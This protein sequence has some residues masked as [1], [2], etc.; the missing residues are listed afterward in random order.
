[1]KMVIAGGRNFIGCQKD[2]NN[3][4]VIVQKYN[5]TEIISG[6]AKGADFFGEY[7]A[8]KMN[9]PVKKFIPDWSY[10]HMAGPIRN[11]QMAK[12]TDYVFLFPGGRGTDSMRREA[13][14]AGKEILYDNGCIE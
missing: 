7:C 3:V 9:I 4:V 11:E 6:D 12:Y 13:K 8:E 14:K 2:L 5:I 10:G 1:M